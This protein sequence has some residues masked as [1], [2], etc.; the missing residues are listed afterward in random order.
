MT[1]L[2]AAR[3]AQGGSEWTRCDVFS[4]VMPE[5]TPPA[6]HCS[7]YLLIHLMIP[8]H[9]ITL[10]HEADNL[11]W[12]VNLTCA[13]TGYCQLVIKLDEDDCSRGV[14]AEDQVC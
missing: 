5:G 10:A 11:L 3:A 9:A 8:K 13:V 12:Y 7:E 2:I 14:E 1:H 4:P 6:C